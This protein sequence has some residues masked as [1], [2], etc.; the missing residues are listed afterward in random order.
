M[1]TPTRPEVGP[2]TPWSFPRP[3]THRLPNGLTLKAFH[4]PGQ[5]VISVRT[6]IPLSTTVE[7]R[8][9][10]G[11][12]ALMSRLLDEGTARHTS[13]EFA[14]LMER[15]G[16]ALGAGMS[17]G[18]LGVDLD[19]PRR[20]LADALDVLR[21]VLAEPA[22]PE[23]EVR[24]MIRSRLAEIEQERALA[25]HRA[26]REFIA[27]HFDASER[28]SRP[29]AGRPETVSA[30]TREDLVDFHARHVGPE[31]ATMVVAGDLSDLDLPALVAA[32]L[33][34]WRPQ[35]HVVP[36]RPT[37]APQRA[38]DAARIVIV[39]RPGSVQ[40]E[41]C[42]GWDG[43]DRRAAGWAA[44]PVLGYVVGGSPTA[45]IDDV[46][47]EEKGYTYGIRSS[48]R[49]RHAGGL[50]VT[51]GSVRSDATVESLGLLLDILQ[52]AREGFSEEELRAGVDFITRTAPGRF[53]TADAVADEA[54]ARALD[55]LPDDFTTDNLARMRRLTRDDLARAYSEVVTGDWTVVIVGDA[56]AHAEAVRA[57]GRGP[58]SVIGA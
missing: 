23:D 30:I 13:E 29:S 9:R 18:G 35:L 47:R 7:R 46:L 52:G 6:V 38:H 49:P 11:I 45:R 21:Q 28:A 14:E 12:A 53:A 42:I 2:P 4:L 17:D 15:K 44:Y 3:E 32:T 36:E 22:F 19:V 26:M 24:R 43:P 37:R 41:F 16:I 33:G 10:E 34:E 40:T 48:F 39:D 58:V 8:D 5:Y 56:G 20:N 54:A 51:S 55:D 25:P 31:G 1:S 27:T 50:F 57:L